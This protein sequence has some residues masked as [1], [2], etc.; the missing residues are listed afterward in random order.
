M[1]KTLME[2]NWRYTMFRM[3]LIGVLII[4]IPMLSSCKKS[5]VGTAE[6]MLK[7]KYGCEFIVERIGNSSLHKNGT[8]YSVFCRPK[9]NKDIIFECWVNNEGTT[10]VDKYKEALIG[11]EMKTEAEDI[12]S[13]LNCDYIMATDV[14]SL[15][16]GYVE[17][18]RISEYGEDINCYTVLAIDKDSLSDLKPYKLYKAIEDIYRNWRNVKGSLFLYLVDSDSMNEIR[19]YVESTPRVDSALFNKCGDGFVSDVDKNGIN[20]S[21]SEMEKILY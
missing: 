16:D 9:N 5:A 13:S 14:T 1:F 20:K 17:G 15:V 11:N 18:T 7:E 6:K 3:I 10:C 21:L 19:E 2:K 4:S 12:L 8:L